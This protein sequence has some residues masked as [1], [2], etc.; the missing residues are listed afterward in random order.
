MLVRALAA[1][2]QLD[3]TGDVQ[4]E[5]LTEALKALPLM[6]CLSSDIAFDVL[7]WVESI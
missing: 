3:S 4:L 1:G 6:D 2:V 7:K 5:P